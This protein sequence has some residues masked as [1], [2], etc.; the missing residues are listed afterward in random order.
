MISQN[1]SCQQT[2]ES[3]FFKWDLNWKRANSECL[4]LPTL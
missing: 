4:N 2:M 1:K 3:N